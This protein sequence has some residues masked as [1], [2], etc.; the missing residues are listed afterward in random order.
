MK[1][2]FDNVIYSLQRSGGISNYWTEITTRFLRDKFD[3]CFYEADKNENI[4]FSKLAR[5]N[6]DVKNF[7]SRFLFINRFL[8]VKT[9]FIKEKFIFHSSYNRTTSNKNAIQIVTIHDFIHEKFYV[10]SPRG[11]IHTFQKKIAIKNAHGII[12]VSNNTKNDLLKYYPSI[13]SDKIRV[14]Y[15]GVSED[16]FP[17]DNVR[18]RESDYFLYVGSREC[19]KNFYF[20]VESVAKLTSKK[21]YIVGSGLNKKEISYLNQTIPKRWKI[22]TNVDNKALNSLY[23]EAFALLYLSS[24]EGFGIPLLE[25]MR[26]GCPFIAYNYSSIPE[27]AGNAGVLINRL[28]F[29]SFTDAVNRIKKKRELILKNGYD[30][31]KMFSWEKCYQETLKFYSELYNQ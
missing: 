3:V 7:Q 10:N 13:D 21:L 20:T 14:I 6:R 29:N 9:D 25:A 30:Q 5:W 8:T 17:L 4:Y 27:V 11:I 12:A 15:N 19:Y 26:A 31:S 24:Y 22:F 2:L 16:F 18:N 28:D 1:T 23:N